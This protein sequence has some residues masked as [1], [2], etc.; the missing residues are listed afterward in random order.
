[1]YDYVLVGAGSAGCVLANRLTEDEGASVLLLEAGGPDRQREIHIPVAFPNLFKGPCDWAYFTEPEPHLGGRSLFWPR[2]KVL[3][4]SSSINAMIYV[5]GHSLDYDGWHDAG[6]KGWNYAS[7]LPYFKRSEDQER[8]ASEYHAVGGPLHVADLRSPNPL[9]RAF[10]AAG[11]SLGWRGNDD[12][13]GAE[14]EGVG[15]YQVTQKRGRRHSAA[16]AFL[17]PLLGRR[18]NLTVHTRAHATRLLFRGTRATGVEYLWDGLQSTAEAS[19]E[20]VLCGGTVNS[21]QLLLLAGVGPAEHLREAGI[22]VVAD[23][24]GVGQNLQD[25][26]AVCVSYAC[27]RPITLAVAES[28]GN[29]LKYL[30][31]GRGMLT[32]NVAEAGA[33]VKTRPDLSAPDLQFH[34]GPAF[35]LDHGTTRPAGH[36]FSVGPALLRPRSRGTLTLR[37]ADPLAQPVIRPNYLSDP[38]DLPVLVEGVRLARAV[39]R[40]REFQPFR[41]EE[42]YP[43]PSAKTDEDLADHVRA[44]GETLY[45]PVGTCKMGTDPMA[46]VDPELRVRG[47]EGLRVVDAS[48]MPSIVGGNTN[49]PTIMI[50]EKAADLITGRGSLSR[51]I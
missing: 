39:V 6:N 13:N 1:M 25:H 16:A 42:N 32:S 51:G 46:V 34:F 49:A 4:G 12:F 20:V 17:T 5:R 31:F 41:G 7:V 14:Q 29:V 26:L 30:F 8:G 43:G 27:T 35:Y 45:H 33:F 2:G 9:A 44:H 38:A 23:L 22:P 11:R 21:P 48:V 15:L 36:W 19:R 40:S 37:S 28:L 10:V 50:A 47:V 3:G 18:A 24:P